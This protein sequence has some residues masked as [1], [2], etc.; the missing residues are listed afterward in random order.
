V[1]GPFSG[2]GSCH[3]LGHHDQRT[4]YR[5]TNT[6]ISRVASGKASVNIRSQLSMMGTAGGVT[7]AAMV[8][9]RTVALPN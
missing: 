7:L 6:H 3:P 8:G 9:T 4:L 1:D 5:V 2:R